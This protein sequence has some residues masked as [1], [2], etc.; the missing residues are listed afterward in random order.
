[1]IANR[2]T[3][4]YRATMSWE[5]G[6]PYAENGWIDPAAWRMLRFFGQRPHEPFAAAAA[7]LRA[8]DYLSEVEQLLAATS[9][10]FNPDF[11][12]D[13]D[14][15]TGPYQLTLFLDELGLRELA[16]RKTRCGRQALAADPAQAPSAT[17][18]RSGRTP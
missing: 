2:L 5:R 12:P 7:W 8:A 16:A 18:S 14:E 6:L 9:F 3:T 1:V 13:R 17:P 11:D 15:A 10:R 4:N